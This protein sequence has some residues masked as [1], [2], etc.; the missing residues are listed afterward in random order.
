MTDILAAWKENNF[1]IADTELVADYTNT[2]HLVVLTNIKFWANNSDSLVEWCNKHQ[3]RF[4]G[5]TVVIPDEHTL[6]LFV[7]KWS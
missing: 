4:E 2:P 5:M 1:I 7:L 3:C 6:A